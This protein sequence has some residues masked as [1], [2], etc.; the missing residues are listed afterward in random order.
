VQ[1]R[2]HLPGPAT[3]PDLGS[4]AVPAA[5]PGHA[6]ALLQRL[7]LA[8]ELTPDGVAAALRQHPQLR[9]AVLREASTR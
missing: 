3:A 7:H 4:P 8:G 6:Q 2:A 9:D 5:D 1:D